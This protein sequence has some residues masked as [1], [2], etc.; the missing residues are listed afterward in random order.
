MLFLIIIVS[1]F[2]LIVYL[3]VMFLYPEWVGIS[4]KDSKQITEEQKEK[5]GGKQDGKQNDT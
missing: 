5:L 1:V 2:S 4:G 3:V